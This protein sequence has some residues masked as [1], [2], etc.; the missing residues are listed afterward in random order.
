MAAKRERKISSINNIILFVIKFCFKIEVMRLKIILD[1][2]C[3][4]ISILLNYIYISK[5]DIPIQFFSAFIYKKKR[6]W[7]VIMSCTEMLT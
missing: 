6:I 2:V 5:F 3:R 7:A 1:F 4:S